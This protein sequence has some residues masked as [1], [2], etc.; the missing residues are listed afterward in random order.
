MRL[1]LAVITPFTSGADVALLL[2]ITVLVRVLVL[3]APTGEISAKP[4]P[5][6]PAVLPAMVQFCI[7]SELGELLPAG[8]RYP[9]LFSPIPP[10]LVAAVLPEIVVLRNTN[11]RGSV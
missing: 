5:L 10:L 1:K 8:A 9:K 6:V 7:V 2:A 11:P 3:P 4:P